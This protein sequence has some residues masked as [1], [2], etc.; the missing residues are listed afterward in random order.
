MKLLDLYKTDNGYVSNWI[1][2]YNNNVYIIGT[3]EP[4]TYKAVETNEETEEES[5]CILDDI[6]LNHL[7][8]KL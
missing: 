6:E 1:N 3:I 8:S 4:F 7:K 5:W 2:S